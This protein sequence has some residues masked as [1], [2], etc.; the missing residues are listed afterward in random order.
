MTFENLTFQRGGST[1]SGLKLGTGIT[2]YAFSSTV[3]KCSFWKIG[4]TATGGALHINSWHNNILNSHFEECYNGINLDASQANPTGMVIRG[5]VFG[6]T[7]SAVS[8]DI[9]TSGSALAIVIDGCVFAHAQPSGGSPNLY[10]SFGAASTGII[11]N[12][13]LATA[14]QT[15]ATAMTNNGVLLANVNYAPGTNMT[16]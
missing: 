3:N 9:S 6:Q 14:T 13:V 7:A 15:I 8:C 4:S 5:C 12:C 11:S 1:S 10:I 2:P 16:S